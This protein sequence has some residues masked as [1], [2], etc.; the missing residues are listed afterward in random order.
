MTKTGP[1][2]IG[3]TSA[4][5]SVHLVVSEI[6]MGHSVT[7]SLGEQINFNLYIQC[8]LGLAES[9]Y[10]SVYNIVECSYFHEIRRG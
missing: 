6:R 10:R 7:N 4:P 3:T 5:S 9:R 8:T 1:T 2:Y